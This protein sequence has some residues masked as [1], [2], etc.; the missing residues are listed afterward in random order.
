MCSA[1]A[2]PKPRGYVAIGVP[3]LHLLPAVWWGRPRLVAMSAPMSAT[4]SAACPPP[5]RLQAADYHHA[6]GYAY[7]KQADYAM[8]VAEYTNALQLNP[9]HLKALFNRGF[10]YDKVRRSAG[11]GVCGSVG[12]APTHSHQRP[13]TLPKTVQ[14]RVL[15]LVL[16]REQTAG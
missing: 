2:V 13:A 9:H 16:V 12:G 4:M 14:S 15:S 3:L 5:R 10:S 6:K 8:A 11:G 7:R 1:P